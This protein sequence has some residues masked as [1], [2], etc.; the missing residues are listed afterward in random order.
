VTTYDGT[1]V[2][3]AELLGA[4]LATLDRGLAAAPGPRCSFTTPT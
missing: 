3:L 2:A 1:Y 4:P